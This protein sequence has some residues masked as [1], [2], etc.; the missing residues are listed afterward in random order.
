MITDYRSDF[1]DKVNLTKISQIN[2]I[3]R[4][5]IQNTECS[6]VNPKKVVYNSLR[7][8]SPEYIL[9]NSYNLKHDIWSAG[10]I[11][12]YL[13]M[14]TH[15]YEEL[16]GKSLKDIKVLEIKEMLGAM[17]AT[18]FNFEVAAYK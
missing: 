12:H 13:L 11:F 17:S 5:L 14:N 7:F 2:S 8:K 4:N 9:G 15:L 1:S 6:N 3:E 10:I 18:Q 16:F